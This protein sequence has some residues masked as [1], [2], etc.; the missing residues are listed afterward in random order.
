MQRQRHPPPPTRGVSVSPNISCSR[1]AR[2]GCAGI[3]VVHRHPRAARHRQVR[4]RQP[5]QRRPLLPAQQVEQRR[6]QIHPVQIAPAEQARRPAGPSH[7]SK[8]AAAPA[9][10]TSGQPGSRRAD[11]GDALAG[12][13]RTVAP[14]KDA[15]APRFAHPRAAPPPPARGRDRGAPCS[16]RTMA[17]S[18]SRRRA[19]DRPGL[20]APTPPPPR[21]RYR[22]RTGHGSPR[23]R[24]VPRAGSGSRA[25]GHPARGRRGSPPGETLRIEEGTEA[26]PEQE[27]PGSALAAAARSGRDRPARAGT[28]TTPARSLSA[29]LGPCPAARRSFR[30]R[31]PQGLAIHVRA[32]D[33][34]PKEIEA[35]PDVRLGDTL[36]S[37]QEV[38]L[39]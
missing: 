32:H 6:R 14:G 11:E 28:P 36:R 19:S 7:P 30:S 21:S 17:P 24:S 12:P 5:I 29:P 37:T 18:R 10:E 20:A 15:R 3:A 9:S 39:R 2:T 13:P 8:D 4:R 38:A 16:R 33:R 1:T 22:P 26:V 31:S 35:G 34:P 23:A 27:S 25:P